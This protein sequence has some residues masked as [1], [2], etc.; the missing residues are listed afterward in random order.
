MRVMKHLKFGAS[1]GGIAFFMM[2]AA[3]TRTA[4]ARPTAP[5]LFCQVYPTAQQCRGTIATCTVCHTAAPELNPY[6]VSVGSKLNRDRSFESAL[7]DALAEVEGAD[8]DGDGRSNAQELAEGSWPGV[9]S[10]YFKGTPGQNGAVEAEFTYRRMSS[11]FCGRS[12]T[13]EEIEELERTSDKKKFTHDRLSSCLKGSY[14]RNEALVHIADPL[15]RAVAL[16]GSCGQA[17]LDYEPDY[18]LFLWAMTDGHNASELLT[19]QYFVYRSETDYVTLTQM[20]D[21]P[22]ARTRAGVKCSNLLQQG[23]VPQNVDK[24]YRAGMLTTAQFLLNNTQ[25]YMPRVSAGIAY[26]NWIGADIAQYQG[27]Y[28]VPNEPRDIDEKNIKSPVCASC[29]ATLEPLTY[30]YAYYYGPGGPKGFGGYSPDR[31][32]VYL[33]GLGATRAILDRWYNDQP[34]AYI[35]GKPLGREQDLPGTSSLVK[36][37][38]EAANSD[39]FSRHISRLVYHEAVGVY[40]EPRDADEFDD[41]RRGLRQDQFSIDAF[42]HKLIDTKAFG[43]PQ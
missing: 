29:H 27:L 11:A 4:S 43:S 8:A 17:F 24:P 33:G 36:L 40:P 22:T 20:D 34:E 10:S 38:R 19:A 1:L 5:S 7:P 18:N 26:R 3:Y 9:A 6:G 13:F 41:L 37:A 32:E 25:A 23:A 16:L 28:S 30:A 21:L 2:H 35:F 42:C 12:A 39:M 15:I 31:P 14:W